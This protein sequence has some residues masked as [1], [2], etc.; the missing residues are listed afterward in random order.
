MK[1]ILSIISPKA[2]LDIPKTIE[3]LYRPVG[4][5]KC[6]GLGFKGRIG[7]FEVLT[8]TE[9]IEK[10]ILEMGSEREITQAALEDGMITM[11]Q[12]GIL[13]AIEGLTSMDEV[14]HVTGQT[15]FLEDIYEK[16]MEQ[17][18]SRAIDISEEDLNAVSE[19]MTSIETL[20]EY[21]KDV[22]AKVKVQKE[23]QAKAERE[24]KAIAKLTENTEVVI[25]EAMIQDEMDQMMEQFSQ[26]LAYQG[27]N[28]DTYCGY[29]GTTKD[30]FR[31]TLRENA[32]KDVKFK[33]AL[34]VVSKLEN[35][36]VTDE[37]IDAKIDELSAQYGS[38]NSSN[39]KTNENARRYM[40]EK[41]LQE[42]TLDIIVDSVIEK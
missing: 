10:L 40:K 6:H 8:I 31:E 22:E 18:M 13:K 16:L 9:S 4:C 27:L 7:I 21:K 11:A 39:L 1:K 12:D 15:D 14:W 3:K 41:L 34:E 33:L 38:D 23:N 35:I 37:E 19:N 2:K 25:P 36:E 26:N 20:E 24:T 28:I 32:E 30:A 29:M 42:K 17:S 5:D